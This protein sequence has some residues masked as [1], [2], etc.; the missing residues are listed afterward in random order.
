MDVN[1]VIEV[2]IFVDASFVANKNGIDIFKW[3]PKCIQMEKREKIEEFNFDLFKFVAT[4]VVLFY[5]NTLK[6]S[7][8]VLVYDI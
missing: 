1:L 6:C 5:L 7:S 8:V 4:W 3:H 2:G